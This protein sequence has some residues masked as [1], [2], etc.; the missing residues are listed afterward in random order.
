MPCDIHYLGKNVAYL[1]EEMGLSRKELGV[2]VGVSGSNISSIEQAK[3]PNPGFQLIRNLASIFGVSERDLDSVDVKKIDRQ[4]RAINRMM[5]NFNEADWKEVHR[6][7]D[8]ITLE[9]CKEGR[10]CY[11]PSSSKA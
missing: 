1:R 10:Y 2:H 11:E 4:Q 8:A 5:M 6:L 9:Q 7:V 3:T